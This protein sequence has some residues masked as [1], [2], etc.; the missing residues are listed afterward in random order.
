[1]ISSE[2]G[3]HVHS[4]LEL[5]IASDPPSTLVFGAIS[6]NQNIFCI[7]LCN[8]RLSTSNV[9]A[10]GLV[11]VFEILRARGLFFRIHAADVFQTV[12]FQVL[13]AIAPSTLEPR[14][15]QFF[16]SGLRDDGALPS[17]FARQ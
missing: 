16:Q 7:T 6:R 9:C 10:V 15:S 13:F 14:R 8:R 3:Q 1:M 17:A 5:V 2:Y 12:A 4:C 11:M